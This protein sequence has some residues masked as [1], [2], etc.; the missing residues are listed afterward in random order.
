M[1]E[2]SPEDVLTALL[3]ASPASGVFLAG[4]GGNIVLDDDDGP[5]LLEQCQ[6][7]HILETAFIFHC[8][9]CAGH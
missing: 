4:Q 9:S 1:A 2:V 6:I 8:S 5:P 7:K 3:L